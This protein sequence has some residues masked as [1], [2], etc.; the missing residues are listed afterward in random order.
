MGE[1]EEVKNVRNRRV[2]SDLHAPFF[3]VFISI[4]ELVAFIYYALRTDEPITLV[5]PVP[6]GSKL[7]YNPYR[8]YEFWRYLTYMFIHAG[9]WH[10]TFNLL[11]QLA[12]GVPLEMVHKSSAIFIIYLGGIIGGAL[13]NSI[14]DSHSYLA[15]ASSG[16]YALIA[17]HLSNLIINWNELKGAWCKLILLVAFSL[18]DFGTAIYER[19]FKIDSVAYR[20]SYGGHIAGALCGLLLG[21]IVLKNSRVHQ[22]EQVASRTS[23]TIISFLFLLAITFN[24][25]SSDYFP[26]PDKRDLIWSQSPFM[27]EREY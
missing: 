18:F 15:G 13:G 24:I 3:M 12:V 9:F 16:C 10:I 8:R 22:W 27:R 25:L 5:G 19:H 6:F 20:T 1:K 26:L 4:F 7:I 14:A 17:A 11:I 21:L 23:L 2:A